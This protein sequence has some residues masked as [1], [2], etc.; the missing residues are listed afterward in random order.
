[1]LHASVPRFHGWV[2]GA[3]TVSVAVL[4]FFGPKAI[5]SRRYAVLSTLFAGAAVMAVHDRGGRRSIDR[6]SVV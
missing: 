5:D 4:L 6:K 1:M 3:L 2:A